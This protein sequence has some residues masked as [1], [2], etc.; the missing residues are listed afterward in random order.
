L[1]T[2]R[3][4]L[5]GSTSKF[6]P[7]IVPCSVAKMKRL[8]AEALPITKSEVLLNATPV[9]AAVAPG[10]LPRGRGILTTSG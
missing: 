8:G 5:T 1:S 6:Q 9:G 7:L 3:T 2:V 10:S 4:A